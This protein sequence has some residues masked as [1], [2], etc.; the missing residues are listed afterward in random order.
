MVAAAEVIAAAEVVVGTKVVTDLDVAV[1]V[2]EVE[3]PVEVL[4]VAD[5]EFPV[6][7][8]DEVFDPLLIEVLLTDDEDADRVTVLK[9]VLLEIV[10]VLPRW[11][12]LDGDPEVVTAPEL[13]V[14]G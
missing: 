11:I 8:A 2:I 4:E 13:V 10:D 12:E 5:E 7:V 3:I 1:L 6:D 14:V 9:V